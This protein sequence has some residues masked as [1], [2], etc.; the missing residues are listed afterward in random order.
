MNFGKYKI[1]N[2]IATGG[3]AEVFK[4]KI[5]GEMGFEKHLVLKKVLPHLAAEE[6]W[7]MSFIDEAKLAALLQHENIIHIY[8][9][10]KTDDNWFLAMEYLSGRDLKDVIIKS[11]K[12]Q[13]SL[14][15]ENILHIISKICDGLE[16]AHQLKGHNGSPLNIIHRDISPQNI[17]ITFDGKV[18]IIDFGIARA[19][20]RSVQTQTGMIKGKLSYMSP[21]QASGKAIDHRSDIF[22]VG[23]LLY[24]LLTGKRMY[25][26][27]VS[28]ILL[29]VI[30]ADYEPVTNLL[31]D[32]P[33]E[34]LA[35]IEK[36]LATDPDDRYQSAGEMGAD[37]ENFMYT[38]NLRAGSRTLADYMQTIFEDDYANEDFDPSAL[39]DPSSND[40]IENNPDAFKT[41]ALNT[42]CAD[43]KPAVGIL[44]AEILPAIKMRLKPLEK[45][46][47]LVHN[48]ALETFE[49]LKKSK[50]LSRERIIAALVCVVLLTSATGG[51]LINK[52]NNQ[53]IA[54]LLTAA[55]TSMKNGALT[56]PPDKSA[57]FYYNEVLD[58]DGDNEEA[59][60]GIQKIVQKKINL[61]K[62]VLS[63]YR[64][65]AAL[66][67][68]NS[69]LAI[70]P[71]NTELLELKTVA[72]EEV[73]NRILGNFKTLF[74]S[75]DKK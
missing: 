5:T 70:D 75:E 43:E 23:V 15:L 53:N 29:K 51:W 34:L 45:L 8:D 73:G 10:G 9:F 33:P 74:N 47:T 31:E 19:A 6:K 65:T 49:L 60:A 56:D 3:M 2:K 37:I 22:A 52:R 16:Y 30:Q 11:I 62:M 18:K 72:E 36:A 4:A 21:E 28:E 68:I 42:N 58:I 44:S 27:E 55:E 66:E 54:E 38:S 35:I 26:G 57:L 46:P 71:E 59:E 20:E 48:R 12:E 13:N 41:A 17:F 67:Y 39:P 14:T 69:G 64:H 1:I 24:E 7:I 50:P 61:A 40:T 32:C 63:R 25:K